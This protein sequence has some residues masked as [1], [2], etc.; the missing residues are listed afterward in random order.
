MQIHHRGAAAAS[1]LLVLLLLSAQGCQ[2][3]DTSAAAPS[4]DTAAAAPNAPGQNGRQEAAGGAAGTE[5]QE[6]SL[7]E[8]DRIKANVPKPPS[9]EPVRGLYMTGWTT[10]GTK[11]WGQLLDLIDRTELNAVVIDV[12]E[13]GELAYDVDVPL[14]KEVKANAKM[15]SNIDA[16]LAELRKRNIYPIA[17]IVCFR[18][19]VAPKKRRDLAV[20]KPDGTPWRDASGHYWL[21]PYNK[22]NWD[23]NI[24]VAIDAAK[25][26]FGEIQWDYV[27]F[28]SEGGLNTMRFPAKAKDDTRSKARVIANFLEYAYERL[29]PYGVVVS[30]DIFGL[31]VSAKPDDDMGI[32]QKIDLMAEH[33]DYICPMIYPSHYNK[34]EY[35]IP[36]PNASPYRTV[37]KALDYATDRMKGKR[38]KIRP[39][40]QDFSLGHRYGVA[41]VRAQMKASREHGINEFLFWNAGNRYTAAAFAPSK[42][43]Q[44]ERARK[45]GTKQQAQSG[46]E[47]DSKAAAGAASQGA[48]GEKTTAGGASTDGEKAG[49]A[50]AQQP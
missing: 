14:A 27:R 39:W 30:A 46:A 3:G 41:E 50:A 28:P 5:Q 16:K 11:R 48:S 26:G 6:A 45:K 19:E 36:N 33:L 7:S 24:D 22:K 47:A 12:R 18:D 42:E 31:T 44:A 1:L 10:G 35:G 23:Y 8:A 25:R 9:D 21:D 40:L 37:H 43:I 32:G 29:K 20:Q 38:C 13:D 15:I 2:N 4:G 17:R 34:G 49:A